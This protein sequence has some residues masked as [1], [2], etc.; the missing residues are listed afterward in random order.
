[1]INFL[2][3]NPITNFKRFKIYVKNYLNKNIINFDLKQNTLCNF[4]LSMEKQ[5]KIFLV[6]IAYMT[7]I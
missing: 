7:N 2:N 6:F 4:F 5:F 3:N 1:M